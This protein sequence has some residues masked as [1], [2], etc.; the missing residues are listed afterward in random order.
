MSYDNIPLCHL[1]SKYWK[2]PGGTEVVSYDRLVAELRMLEG[3]RLFIDLVA[4]H[5]HIFLCSGTS[6]KL[7]Y[8][9]VYANRPHQFYT[10]DKDERPF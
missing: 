7:Q 4:V 2:K 10:L 1:R 5:G 9:E 8:C 6:L 3:D